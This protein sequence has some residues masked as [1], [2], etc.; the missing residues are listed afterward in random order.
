MSKVLVFSYTANFISIGNTETLGLSNHSFSIC[1]WVKLDRYN[2]SNQG[3]N[4][5][6][7]SDHP[8]PNG[9]LH[10]VLRNGYP[11]LGFY[12]NDVVA[13]RAID[14]NRWYHLSFVYNIEDKTQ[15]IY[16]N[17]KLSNS[18]GNHSPLEGSAEVYLSEYVGSRGLN[19]R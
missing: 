15:S 6:L 12:G 3:D 14:I 1:V 16:I 9:C 7:G 5:I 8:I 17:G 13:N 18:S 11:Y 19:G 10:L 2:T 4:A